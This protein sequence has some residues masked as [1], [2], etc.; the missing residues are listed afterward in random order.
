MISARLERELT[1]LASRLSQLQRLV[2]KIQR[3]LTTPPEY[4]RMTALRAGEQMHKKHETRTGELKEVAE[5][6]QL[7]LEDYP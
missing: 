6:T 4:D 2:T 5:P 1:Y 7:P 3:E